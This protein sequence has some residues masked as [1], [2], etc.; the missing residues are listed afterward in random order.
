MPRDH[1]INIYNELDITNVDASIKQL[2]EWCEH[3]LD[4][5]WNIIADSGSCAVR[6][7]GKHILILACEYSSDVVKFKL[8]W[9]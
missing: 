5:G 7:S 8:E 9:L 2:L 4:Y 3:N 6:G 1:K